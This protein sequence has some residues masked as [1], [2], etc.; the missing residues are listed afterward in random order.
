MELDWKTLV[1]AKNRGFQAYLFDSGWESNPGE[2]S[3]WLEGSLGNYSSPDDKLPGF[4]EFLRSARQDLGM[5]V[6]LWLAP[7]ALGRESIFYEELKDAHVILNK[8]RGWYHGGDETFPATVEMDERFAENVN[9]CPRTPATPAHLKS[10]FRRLGTDYQPDGY[11]LDFQET[12]PFLCEAQHDHNT[13]FACG[14]QQSQAS[15]KETVLEQKCN[16]TVEMRYPGANLNNKRFEILAEHRFPGFRC[17][18]ALHF[19]DAP[20][21]RRCRQVPTKCT[22]PGNRRGDRCSIRCHYCLWRSA[23]HRRELVG[24]PPTT[25]K[26]PRLG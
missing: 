23:G 11:W 17:D 18:A 3:R 25:R 1:Q 24:R 6:I 16:A 15:I 22:G 12:V 4:A 13:S 5:N 20:F 2:L 14:F 26:S 21:Q 8:A 19:D 9:L 7:Y 10:L